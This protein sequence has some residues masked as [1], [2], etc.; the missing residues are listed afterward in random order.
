MEVDSDDDQALC[1]SRDSL[2]MIEAKLLGMDDEQFS[3]TTARMLRHFIEDD[4]NLQRDDLKE[5]RNDMFEILFGI[6][7]DVSSRRICKERI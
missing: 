7:Q 3:S 1:L 6:Y 4:M 2:Q 5:Y